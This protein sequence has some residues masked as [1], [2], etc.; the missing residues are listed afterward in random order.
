MTTPG[1]LLM[2]SDLE[3]CAEFDNA[4]S[5]KVKQTTLLCKTPTFQALDLFLKTKVKLRQ[6]SSACHT[7]Y[8][9]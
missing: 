8:R 1:K 5:V 3:G 2:I 6:F 9:Y 4:N 7:M